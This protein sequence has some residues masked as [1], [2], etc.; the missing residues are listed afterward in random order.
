MSLPWL[1]KRRNWGWMLSPDSVSE[2]WLGQSPV[3]DSWGFRVFLEWGRDAAYKRENPNPKNPEYTVLKKAC[4]SLLKFHVWWFASDFFLR[5]S[6]NW[7]RLWTAGIMKG[8][9]GI[10]ASRKSKRM[11]VIKAAVGAGWYLRPAFIASCPALA[12]QWTWFHCCFLRRW[13]VMMGVKRYFWLVLGGKGIPVATACPFKG[14]E[15]KVCWFFIAWWFFWSYC[16]FLLCLLVALAP[17]EKEADH[18][19]KG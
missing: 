19:E 17:E 7:K 11:I 12:P 2:K 10:A 15:R 3:W 8:N 6:A 13:G 5:R 4:F 16:S 14:K 18:L 9:G 1:Q